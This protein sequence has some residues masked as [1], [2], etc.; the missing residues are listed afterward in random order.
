MSCTSSAAATFT[1]FTSTFSQTNTSRTWR[2]ELWG[3]RDLP[4]GLQVVGAAK[5]LGSSRW[6]WIGGLN[7]GGSSLTITSLCCF[8]GFDSCNPAQSI[9]SPPSQWLGKKALPGHDECGVKTL[10][11]GTNG[12]KANLW[13]GRKWAAQP[14]SEM[15]QMNQT[16]PSSIPTATPATVPSR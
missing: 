16:L 2:R 6:L 1:F 10:N 4:Q 9:I 3:S 11:K 14:Q 12:L 15:E 8:T 5:H 13:V 7:V